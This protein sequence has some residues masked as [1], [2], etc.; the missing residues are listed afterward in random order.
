MDKNISFH[1]T[2]TSLQ[3][4][5]WTLVVYLLLATGCTYDEA[6]VVPA[7]EEEAISVSYAADIQPIIAANCY[8]CHTAAATDPDKAG[9]AFL[10]NFEELQRY[11]LKPSTSNP[12]L[13]KLQ[14]RIRFIEIPGM[15]FKQEPLPKSEILKIEAW[16]KIGAPNN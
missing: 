1:Y 15:P 12:N 16:I 8:S 5:L 10:D 13:T 7:L 9:Y 6:L 14:A 2:T 11:A 4:I 3:S